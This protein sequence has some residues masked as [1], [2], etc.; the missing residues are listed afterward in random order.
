[1]TATPQK[2]RQI[3]TRQNDISTW[4]TGSVVHIIRVF[5]DTIPD[6]Q[7]RTQTLDLITS[8][9][10]NLADY[11]KDSKVQVLLEPNGD[12]ATTDDLDLLMKNAGH[13][14]VGILWNVSFMWLTARESPALVYDRLKPYIRHTH[15]KDLKLINGKAEGVPSYDVLLGEGDIPVAEAINISTNKSIP[16]PIVANGRNSGTTGIREPEIA[17]AHFSKQVTAWLS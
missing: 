10:I 6:G 13:P 2:E 8:G 3:S 4:H 12:F 1:M 16:D 15:I 17:L 11:A 14:G 5:P 9:L 7:D